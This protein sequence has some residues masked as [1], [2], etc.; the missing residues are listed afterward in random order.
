MSENNPL[1]TYHLVQPTG[2]GRPNSMTTMIYSDQVSNV[3]P[4]Q[5][6][7]DVKLLCSVTAD[8]S[9]IPENE[10]EQT[11]GVDGQMYYDLEY[12]IESICKYLQMSFQ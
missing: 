5:R 4:L 9:H 2:D 10:L 6:N 8:L 11:L 3:A 7:D 12:Q 1:R